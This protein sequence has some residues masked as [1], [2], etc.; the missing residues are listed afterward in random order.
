MAAVRAL[1]RTLH[2]KIQPTPWPKVSV[3]CDCS[4]PSKSL[5]PRIKVSPMIICS[6]KNVGLVSHFYAMVFALLAC[7]S[8]QAQKLDLNSNG[9]S[10][11]WEQIYNAVALNPN[12]DSDG[13]GVSN[14]RESMAGTDPFDP[15]SVPK[16]PATAFSSSNFSVTL[17]SALGKQYQLQSVQPQV[18]GWTNWTVES[19]I[20]ARTG[21]VVTLT[22]PIGST[23]KFFR[24][25]IADVDTDGDGLNDWEEYQLGLDP[26]KAF[27]N[28]QLDGV[29]QPMGDYAY[30]SAR[31]ASQNVISITATDPTCVQPDTGQTA[32]DLGQFTITRG[33]FP[34]N[35]ISV[36][37]STS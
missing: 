25:G 14:L 3:L 17:P 29:G 6:K 7:E 27:S 34:L 32:G 18:S 37:L 35:A 12:L 5:D 1:R 28:N 19:T 2:N 16:I 9:M 33:G 8:I 36:N 31:I 30:A 26:T 23:P 22:A 20:I 4:R 10:D 15:N 13:D 21:T 11:V 24:V